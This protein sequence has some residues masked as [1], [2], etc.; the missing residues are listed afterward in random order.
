MLLNSSNY[1]GKSTITRPKQMD[2]LSKAALPL[3][4]GCQLFREAVCV[5]KDP[6][7]GELVPSRVAR[8]GL[9][10]VQR[11]A[12]RP[13]RP[14][15]PPRNHPGELLLNLFHQRLKARAEMVGQLFSRTFSSTQPANMLL[16]D[17]ALAMGVSRIAEAFPE[18]RSSYGSAALRERDGGLDDLFHC[19]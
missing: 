15:P 7:A 4:S 5:T 19:R 11:D 10:Q 2:L 12:P 14:A 17:L 16:P 3:G 8:L 9:L 18:R 13:P 6:R 1:N